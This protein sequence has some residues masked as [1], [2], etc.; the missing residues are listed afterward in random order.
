MLRIILRNGTL[1]YLTLRLRL[2]FMCV[3]SIETLNIFFTGHFI[4]QFAQFIYF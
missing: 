4:V 1:R 3:M 2:I